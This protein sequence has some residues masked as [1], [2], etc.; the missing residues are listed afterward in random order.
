MESTTCLYF[1]YGSNL[2][3]RRIEQR[4]GSCAVVGTA[5]LPRH[6]L[7]FHKRGRDGSGKCDVFYTGDSSHGVF[8][9]VY[10]L[11]RRQRRSLDDYEGP[12][13][14]SKALSVSFKFGK[15]DVYTYVARHG[16]VEA[17]LRPFTWYKSIVVAGA[18]VCAFP[19]TYVQTLVSILADRDPDGH[20]EA[21]HLS[22]L[23]DN[24]G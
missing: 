2:L 1:A 5:Y 18:R 23:H 12:G 3:R 6:E 9:N 16:H 24:D 22:L 19:H 7:R 8:G 15:I 10:E 21:Q 20:R 11:S 14:G 4:L 17:G 13:Y